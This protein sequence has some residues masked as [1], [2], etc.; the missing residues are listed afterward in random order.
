MHFASFHSILL[1]VILI[2][3]LECKILINEVNVIDPNTL[4][5]NEYIE[6]KSVSGNETPLR[7]YK[8]VGFNCQSTTGTIDLIVTLWNQKTDKNG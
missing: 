4:H 3:S 7:R 2:S 6:L 8:L 1:N 5:K